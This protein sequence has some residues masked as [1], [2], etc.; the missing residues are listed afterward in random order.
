[1][2]ARTIVEKLQLLVRKLCD[3]SKCQGEGDILVVNL[4]LTN[5][6]N[7]FEKI[8]KYSTTKRIPILYNIS[9]CLEGTVAI[10]VFGSSPSE[11]SQKE[12]NEASGRTKRKNG[13]NSSAINNRGDHICCIH[14][15]KGS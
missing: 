3:I 14:E 4:C 13:I 8:L 12:F 10:T 1:M 6:N 2:N 7:Y 5:F 11:R 15:P 9:K